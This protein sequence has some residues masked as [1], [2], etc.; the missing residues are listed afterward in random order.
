MTGP[1]FFSEFSQVF[2][3]QPYLWDLFPCGLAKVPFPDNWCSWY[4]REISC[5]LRQWEHLQGPSKKLGYVKTDVH[6]K[7]CLSPGLYIVNLCRRWQVTLLY[8][9][10]MEVLT[11][12]SACQ[13]RWC[14]WSINKMC[15]FCLMQIADQ[16]ERSSLD[17]WETRNYIPWIAANHTSSSLCITSIFSEVSPVLN[18]IKSKLKN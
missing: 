9:M 13:N 12:Q 2:C 6:R 3:C 7:C 4:T 11:W 15:D 14:I 8:R 1:V 5:V 16:C 18:I 17:I 10:C